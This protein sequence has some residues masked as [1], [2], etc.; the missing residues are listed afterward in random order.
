MRSNV[1]ISNIITRRNN[2]I[3]SYFNGSL[4][5]LPRLSLNNPIFIL[6]LKARS[7]RLILTFF[8]FFFRIKE[9][10]SVDESKQVEHDRTFQLWKSFSLNTTSLSRKQLF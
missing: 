7:E 3:V 4:E 5:S 9:F 10:D 2:A 6:S 8:F 1:K